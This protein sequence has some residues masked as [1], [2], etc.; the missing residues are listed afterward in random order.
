MLVAVGEKETDDYRRQSRAVAD[1]W[2]TRGNV[3]E[4]FELKGRN[5]FDAVLEWADCGSAVFR[6]SRRLLGPACV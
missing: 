3:A 5:H 6:A 2:R 1:Y 4:L